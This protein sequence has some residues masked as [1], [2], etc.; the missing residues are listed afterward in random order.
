MDAAVD[1]AVDAVQLLA[2]TDTVLV[3]DWP[4]RDVPDTLARR[5]YTVIV[6]GGPGPE[7]YTA[8]ELIGNEVVTRRIGRPPDRVDLVYAH[9]PVAE[10]P[11][12]V[13]TAAALGAAAVWVQ[14]GLS[15]PGTRHPEGCWMPHDHAQTARRIVE[16]AGL[17]YLDHPYIAAAARACPSH[18]R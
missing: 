7:D 6:Q 15:G 12:L 5:G 16:S 3:V 14:S 18:T 13:A 1:A 17:A 2:D 10:L 8:Q 11:Q 4:S 9:R